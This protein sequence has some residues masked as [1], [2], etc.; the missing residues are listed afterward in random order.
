MYCSTRKSNSNRSF[1]YPTP[2]VQV[3]FSC[4]HCEL[5]TDSIEQL[6]IHARIHR[7]TPPQK[8]AETKKTEKSSQSLKHWA[9]VDLF[10]GSGQS[11]ISVTS[12]A[13]PKR[14][15]GSGSGDGASGSGTSNSTNIS[16]QPR[17]SSS[18]ASELDDLVESVDLSGP[19]LNIPNLKLLTEKDQEVVYSIEV[20]VYYYIIGNSYMRSLI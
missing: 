15:S 19:S 16:I 13:Q 8:P 2:P 3:M 6:L 12:N 4:N 14:N 11:V 5:M 1:I 10:N 20:R 9:H 7:I 17:R 18:F